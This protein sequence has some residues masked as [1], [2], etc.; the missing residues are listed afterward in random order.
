M[1]ASE[2]EISFDLVT[3][4]WCGLEERWHCNLLCSTVARKTI[5]RRDS[6]STTSSK[7]FLIHASSMML[8]VDATDS[9]AKQAQNL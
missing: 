1:Q 7:S 5:K 2:P 4:F 3:G 8:P 6:A 9:V